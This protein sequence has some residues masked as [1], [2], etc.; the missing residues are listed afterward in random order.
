MS[1]YNVYYMVFA[2]LLQENYLKK[3]FLGRSHIG[4]LG[5]KTSQWCP[6]HVPYLPYPRYATG[7][8]KSV[9]EI[10]DFFLFPC[11]LFSFC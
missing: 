3:S 6:G 9:N 11:L 8:V 7:G 5:A 2:K 10:T 4:T 1:M